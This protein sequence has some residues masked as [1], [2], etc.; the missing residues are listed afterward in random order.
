MD[1]NQF[2]QYFRFLAQAENYKRTASQLATRH[3]VDKL[4]KQTTL[5]DGSTTAP[6]RTQNRVGDN[7]IIEVVT[8]TVSGS[9]S[10]ENERFIH[11]HITRE[12]VPRAAV[13]RDQLRA[14]IVHSF[15][16]V[17]DQEHYRMN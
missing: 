14:N 11:A 16:C 8:S 7:N 9:L 5:C 6:T 1:A 10:R 3:L 13:P 4:I 15:P 12:N 2:D 17:D